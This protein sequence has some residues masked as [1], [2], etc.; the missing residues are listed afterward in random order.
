MPEANGHQDNLSRL[1]RIERAIEHVINEHEKFLDEHKMLLRAQVIMA[2]A[3][4]NL[5]RTVEEIGGKLNALINIVDHD[6]RE[7]HDRLKRIEGTQ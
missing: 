4:A 1:D 2:D 7:F 5:S 6:H 3:H